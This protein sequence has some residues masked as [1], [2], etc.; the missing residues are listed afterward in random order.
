MRRIGSMNG[1]NRNNIQLPTISNYQELPKRYLDKMPDRVGEI[2]RTIIWKIVALAGSMV[3]FIV[4]PSNFGLGTNDFCNPTPC[5]VNTN[6]RVGDKSAICSCKDG[7]LGDPISGCKRECESDADCSETKMCIKN[8]CK[9]PCESSCGTYAK[10]DVRVNGIFKLRLWFP[11]SICNTILLFIKNH[12]VFC[13]CPENFFGNAYSRCSP[14]CTEHEQCSN[15]LTCNNLK[16]VDPCVEA[17][18]SN[19]NCRAENHTAICSCKKGYTGNPIEGCSPLRKEYLCHPN[20]CGIFAE[21]TPGTDN[22]GNNRPVCSCPP[23]FLGN[24]LVSCEKGE[25]KENSV[26]FDFMIR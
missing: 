9:D 8:Y 18:G 12:R 24:P 23:G 4:V 15:R 13:T 14:E 2:N 5:G 19:T 16:C 25:C 22:D 6:C 7:F 20:P 11:P 1:S 17:C 21:C 3:H 10:C 26:I